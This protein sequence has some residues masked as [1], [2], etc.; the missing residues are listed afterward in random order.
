MAISAKFAIPITVSE[1]RDPEIFEFIRQHPNVNF[2]AELKEV[3]RAWARGMKGVPTSPAHADRSERAPAEQP[4][5]PS[6]PRRAAAGDDSVPVASFSGGSRLMGA[7]AD[8]GG[9]G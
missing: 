7:L 6:A 8:K 5:Q 4:P 3:L 9:E 1:S 2:G